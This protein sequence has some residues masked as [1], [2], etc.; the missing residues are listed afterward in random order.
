MD[1][2]KE[3]E[4]YFELMKERPELFCFSEKYPIVTDKK[5][6][7]DYIKE[8]GKK[9]GVIYGYGSPF[10]MLVADLIGGSNGFYTYTRIVYPNKS[11]GSVIIPIAFSEK[12][13]KLLGFIDIYRHPIRGKTGPEFPRGFANKGSSPSKDALR[14]LAEELRLPLPL[15]VKTLRS[16]GKVS[17]DAGLAS[18]YAEVF[19]AEIEGDYR[20]IGASEDEGIS[21]I[22]FYG[23]KEVK[24]LVTENKI[25]DGF[26]LSALMKYFAALGE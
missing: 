9:L 8:T 15:K 4:N 14:E 11:N 22:S 16:L 23:E 18:G 6:L 17:A 3:I 25:T 21:S 5:I 24:K 13:E 26:T 1:C 10:Y 7:C 19:A 2:Y 12:G 20:L